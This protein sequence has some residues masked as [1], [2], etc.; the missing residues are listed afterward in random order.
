MR[1]NLAVFAL[2]IIM[3]A[4]LPS[5]AADY[6][7]KTVKVLPIESYPARMTIGAV[8]VAADPYPTDEKSFTAFSVKDINS[9]GYFPVHIII[10]NLSPDELSV[11]TRDIMLLLPGGEE[12][13]TTPATLVAVNVVGG[14]ATSTKSGSPLLD[15]TGK[16][17]TNMAVEPG[18]V[19]NG[20]LF[21]FAQG[22][23]KNLFNGATLRIPRIQD[24]TT[25][26][27]LGPFI[28][29]LDPALPATAT[30]K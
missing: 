11:R 7:I 13:Y 27:D 20:F 4:G 26:K 3:S 1:H 28:I 23:K 5:T 8:T 15:F 22:V 25:Q 2:G 14:K 24:E 12:L 16:E 18:V 9:K 10:Q 21:F 29:P 17:L 6:Q 19:A 30:K